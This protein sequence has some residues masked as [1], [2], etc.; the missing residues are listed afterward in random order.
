MG[1]RWQC[2]PFPNDTEQVITIWSK[3]TEV[4]SEIYYSKQLS[5]YQYVKSADECQVK[6]TTNCE[7]LEYQIQKD[8]QF[9]AEHF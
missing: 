7:N 3:C 8:Y 1:I 5:T 9:L 4:T 6:E 2:S